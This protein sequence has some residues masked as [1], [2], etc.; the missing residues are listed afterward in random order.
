MSKHAV[1]HIP[2]T[3][4]LKLGICLAGIQISVFFTFVLY[5]AFHTYPTPLTL[6]NGIPAPFLFGLLVI[7]CGTA[8][9]IL[10][11]QLT[12]RQENRDA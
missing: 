12:N 11:V 4:N 3:E 2:D 8:L 10:Y 5:C 1:T 7:A 9:T 6:D